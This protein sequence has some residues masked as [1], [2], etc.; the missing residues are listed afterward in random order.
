M[1]IEHMTFQIDDEVWLQSD[2]LPTELNPLDVQFTVQLD[3]IPMAN[4]LSMR[5]RYSRNGHVLP[6]ASSRVTLGQ[7]VP[8]WYT[9]GLLTALT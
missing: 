3:N 7:V 1:W 4:L 6:L 8:K 5:W 9:G 2:A